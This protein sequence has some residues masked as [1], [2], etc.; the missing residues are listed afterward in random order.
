MLW[1][2]ALWGQGCSGSTVT[3]PISGD[4]TA[5]RLLQLQWDG[6]QYRWVDITTSVNFSTKKITGT[7]ATDYLGVLGLV[8]ADPPALTAAVAGIG[9]DPVKGF[10]VDVRLSSVG[11]GAAMNIEI[12]ELTLRTLTG[13][14]T[15]SYNTTAGPALPIT[16]GSLAPESKSTVRVYLKSSSSFGAGGVTLFSIAEHLRM[17]DA[18]GNTYTAV[19]AQLITP[20]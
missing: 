20:K 12:T 5:P 4:M 17:Q 18:F 6:A 1:T 3:L 13:P 7:L 16:V 15:V 2:S 8:Q 14:G 10:F 9:T 11:K 19:P